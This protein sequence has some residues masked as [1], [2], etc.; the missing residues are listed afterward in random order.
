[1]VNVRLIGSQEDIQNA[2]EQLNKVFAIGSFSSLR[3]S[4]K[5]PSEFLMYVELL[6]GDNGEQIEADFEEEEQQEEE[7]KEVPPAPVAVPP[8]QKKLKLQRDF[9]SKVQEE[10]KEGQ[11]QIGAG[12][13]IEGEEINVIIEEQQKIEL[14]PV[15]VELLPKETTIK[16][17]PQAPKKSSPKSK[18]KATSKTK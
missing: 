8:V 1:M 18:G 2:M 4:R 15:A 13:E 14:H 5:N 10:I 6:P 12:Q 3:P 11:E 16:K 9:R 7:Q 17:A